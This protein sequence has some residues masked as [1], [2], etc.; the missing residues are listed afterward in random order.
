MKYNYVYLD[1]SWNFDF[2]HNAAITLPSET[3]CA[4]LLCTVEIWPLK[5]P[6][7]VRDL[8]ETLELSSILPFPSW[9]IFESSRLLTVLQVI[10]R[11]LPVA[12][13]ASLNSQT[14]CGP[15]W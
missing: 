4:K 11:P 1:A 13:E 8:R 5:H 7:V 10:C 14:S 9:L 6:S 2:L 3:L 12:W 15:P